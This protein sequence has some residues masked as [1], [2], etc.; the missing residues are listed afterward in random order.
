MS[1][2]F[3]A[4]ER[5]LFMTAWKPPAGRG[6]LGALTLDWEGGQASLCL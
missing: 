4:E 5:C 6:S 3:E 2:C 1:K